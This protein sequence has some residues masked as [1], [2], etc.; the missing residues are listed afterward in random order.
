MAIAA[1]VKTVETKTPGFATGRGIVNVVSGDA[2]SPR[3]AVLGRRGGRRRVVLLRATHQGECYIAM[4][5]AS[6]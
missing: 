1:I 3:P 5:T 2:R 6:T 4:E